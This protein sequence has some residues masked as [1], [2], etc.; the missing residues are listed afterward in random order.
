MVA[1]NFTKV[2]HLIAEETFARTTITRHHHESHL[3]TRIL[4]QQSLPLLSYEGM[5]G[6]HIQ[7]YKFDHSALFLTQEWGQFDGVVNAE[8]E[9]NRV[10]GTCWGL[11]G[12]ARESVCSVNLS[13]FM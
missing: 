12:R 11:L 4:P 9:L 1:T 6:R 8:M 13:G 7:G 3:V 10:V 5:S 2:E